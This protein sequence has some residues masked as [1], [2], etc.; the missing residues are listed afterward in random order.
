[1]INKRRLLR[2]DRI[3]RLLTMLS[4]SI[5]VFTLGAI[6]FFVFSKGL[7][8]VNWDLLT[9]NYYPTVYNTSSSPLEATHFDPPSNLNNSIY[10]SSRWGVGFQ[11]DTNKE[12]GNIIVIAYVD[13]N[14]PFL[15]LKDN[16]QD[17][18]LIAITSG[19]ELSYAI[20]DQEVTVL[21]RYGAQNAAMQFDQA[22]QITS[23]STQY[24]GGGIRS[25]LIT[26]FYLIGLS[27]FIAIPFGIFTALYLNEFAKKNRWT[28][29][30]RSMIEVLTGVPSIIYGLLGAAVFIPFTQYFFHAN[31]GNILAGALTLATII[32]PIII[33]STEEALKT[34][35]IDLRKASLALGANDMNT[36]FKVI[37]PSALP[38]IISG[39]LLG[40]GRIVGESAALIYAIG[41]TIND[42]VSLTGTSTPLSVHIWSVMAG[43]APNFAMASAI[44]II[45]LFVV[46]VLN[47]LV[48][49]L[50]RKLNR[51]N[52][53]K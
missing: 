37:V 52:E 3:L 8:L 38:G 26:T 20:L 34:V 7:H 21:G 42:K 32:L 12:G 47:I 29:I 16:F 45:I 50:S 30:L 6:L 53:V 35:P 1:M 13:P 49:L 43:E 17:N 10:F 28:Q 22:S 11:D 41:T 15:V 36:T 23:M 14:S 24:S 33:R 48:K 40:I 31:G 19:Q 27:L 44:S 9:S 51:F 5:G 46:L 4:S 25:S 2:K 39:I 18:Q